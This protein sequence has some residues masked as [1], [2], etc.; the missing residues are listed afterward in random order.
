MKLSIMLITHN[1]CKE[2]LRA[3]ESCAAYMND[4]MELV[5]VDNDSPDDSKAVLEAYLKS[6]P[7]HALYHKS[8]ENLGVA[9]GRNLAY[10]LC[11]GEL[12]FSLDDDAVVITPD[13]FSILI[14]FM[15]EHPRVAAAE[16]II[17]EPE[18]KTNLNCPFHT[19]LANED[20]EVIRSFCGCAH[21]L[22]KSFYQ[23]GPLYPARLFFGSEELY[24]SLQAWGAHQQ[25]ALIDT[26]VIHHRPSTINRF[27][28]KTRNFNIYINTYLIKKLMYP[29]ILH[30]LI[31]AILTLRLIK[32]GTYD[33]AWRKKMKET[34]K[35]RYDQN[36]RSPI[37]LSTILTLVKQFGFFAIL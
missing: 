22:R 23:N 1:R 33:A 16:V 5:I 19:R 37:S 28:G 8:A 11:Q 30:P 20:H 12:V 18:T 27:S 36:E 35:E 31:R 10:S 14:R 32:H 4:D 24:P 3:V 15:D 34:I 6:A 17:L 13:F 2:L 29:V 21:V 9:G 25:V 7:I 26:L